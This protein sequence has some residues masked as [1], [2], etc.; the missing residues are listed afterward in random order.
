MFR[1]MV[2]LDPELAVQNWQQ[3]SVN[4]AF[5]EFQEIPVRLHRSLI[6]ALKAKVRKVA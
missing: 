4:T 5:V 6:R 1:G 2:T 3:L